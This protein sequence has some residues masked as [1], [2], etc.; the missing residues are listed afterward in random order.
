LVVPDLVGNLQL[1]EDILVNE[2]DLGVEVAVVFAIFREVPDD[3]V[4]D[5]YKPN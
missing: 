2:L 5:L 4:D 3:G 1:Q